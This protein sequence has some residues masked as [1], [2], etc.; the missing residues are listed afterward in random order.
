MQN[1]SLLR[2]ATPLR[3]RVGRFLLVIALSAVF[4]V[5]GATLGMEAERGREIAAIEAQLREAGFPLDPASLQRAFDDGMPSPNGADSYEEALAAIGDGDTENAIAKAIEATAVP[6]T[7]FALRFETLAALPIDLTAMRALGAALH[8]AH[9]EAIENNDL[10]AAHEL[11]SAQWA[12][13][14]ALDEAPL[15]VLQVLRGAL[16]RRAL[17]T[18]ADALS[19]DTLPL[20]ALDA[21]DNQL[22]TI[23][24]RPALIDALAAE[25]AVAL[26]TMR[27]QSQSRSWPARAVS[28]VLGA[29]FA[30]ERWILTGLAE[31]IVAAEAPAAF[32]PAE[33]ERLAAMPESLGRFERLPA[34]MLLPPALRILAAATEDE[35]QL[36]AA[37]AAVT[38]RRFA[39]AH[40]TL[41]EDE[42]TLLTHGIR[43]PEDPLGARSI[44]YERTSTNSYRTW[45][46]G[47][48]G[49]DDR[50]SED[51]DDIV[52]NVEA[53]P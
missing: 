7:R 6:R 46:A 23:D 31:V 10:G 35:A 53:A 49:F 16:T 50:G 19:H 5:T 9:L 21:F 13:A 42:G 48:D 4:V 28:A 30:M 24:L 26:H 20:S 18:L 32:R 8:E 1:Q 45:S 22:A 27:A 34:E 52:F 41:P 11:L 47:L 40:G 29:D 15:L 17:D 44:R 12:L 43:L 37:R 39:R 25:R 33:I 38:V 2:P 36:A 14:S 51:S 3:R